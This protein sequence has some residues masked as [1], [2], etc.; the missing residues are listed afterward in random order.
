MGSYENN[1]LHQLFDAGKDMMVYQLVDVTRGLSA[2]FPV[3]Y[4]GLVDMSILDL[5]CSFKIAGDSEFIKHTFRQFLHKAGI[6]NKE[7]A[8]NTRACRAGQV[9]DQ[10]SRNR[11]FPGSL[12]TGIELYWQ[13]QS[14]RNSLWPLVFRGRGSRQGG[15]GDG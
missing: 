12:T 3:A 15:R 10:G 7:P 9:A 4:P 11:I 8:G 2:L 14:R 6:D 13:F 1:V 5:L